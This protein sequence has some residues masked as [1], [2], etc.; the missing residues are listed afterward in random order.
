MEESDEEAAGDSGARRKPA[1]A[2]A[3]PEDV[4]DE[5]LFELIFVLTGVFEGITREQ[6][7]DFIIS[8]G[9]YSKS[10]VS[11]KTDFL[12][13]GCQLEDGREVT[14]GT[15]YRAAIQKNTTI[16]N[17]SEFEEFI[18]EKTGL[19]NFSFCNRVNMIEGIEESEPLAEKD[20]SAESET[21]WT[22]LYRPKSAND[23]IGN[24]ASVQSL[25][26]W[27]RDWHNVHVHGE[28]KFVRQQT[29]RFVMGAGWQNPPNPNAKAALL[30]GPPGVGKTS[31]C[32]IIC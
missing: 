8:K 30:S 1:D 25:F 32:R 13:V 24:Q 11:G 14:A 10:A 19:E 2:P 3:G 27:L 4:P 22:D 16:M 12:V 7:H 6:L 21:L 29:G 9:G 23:I 31:A 18:R 15:K 28:K 5:A 20:P 26:E 17:E